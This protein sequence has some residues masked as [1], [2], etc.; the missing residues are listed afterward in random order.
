[1]SVTMLSFCIMISNNMSSTEK[2]VSHP[3]GA[4]GADESVPGGW[5]LLLTEGKKKKQNKL[6]TTDAADAS[7]GIRSGLEEKLECREFS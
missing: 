1:M 7:R 2:A 6:E 5:M 3:T 4:S